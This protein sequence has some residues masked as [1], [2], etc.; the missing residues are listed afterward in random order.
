MYSFVLVFLFSAC[1]ALWVLIQ[2]AN[3][4]LFKIYIIVGIFIAFLLFNLLACYK[5]FDFVEECFRLKN[6]KIDE[7][8]LKF[9]SKSVDE[10]Q[11]Y[12]AQ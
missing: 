11:H 2:V 5:A 12:S 4:P 9:K 1:I 7:A 6:V 10:E 8:W 3:T